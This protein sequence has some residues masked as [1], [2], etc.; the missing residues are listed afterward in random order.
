MAHVEGLAGI[1]EVRPGNYAL[2][3]LTQVALGACGPADC[4]GTVLASVVSSSRDRGR[5]IVDA[6]AL[7]LSVDRGAAHARPSFGRLFDAYELGTLRQNARLI[8]L[9]QEHGIVDSPLPV[10]DRVRILPNHICL[11]TACFDAFYVVSGDT[12]VD[13]WRIWRGR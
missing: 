5:S 13:T 10:G 9:S 12:V 8:S 2:Y 7:S 3:D 11:V 1:T 6:G 4:A